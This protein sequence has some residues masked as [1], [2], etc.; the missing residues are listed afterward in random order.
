MTT[1]L[2]ILLRPKNEFKTRNDIAIH[3]LNPNFDKILSAIKD[4]LKDNFPRIVIYSDSG[5]MTRM[6]VKKNS[7]FTK[8]LKAFDGIADVRAGMIEYRFGQYQGD[9]FQLYF[10]EDN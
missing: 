10:N 6:N 1:K 8:L 2:E 5:W 4:A 3:V 9:G 7:T